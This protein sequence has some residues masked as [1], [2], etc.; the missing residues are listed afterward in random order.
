[1]EYRTRSRT[2]AGRGRHVGRIFEQNEPD[3]AFTSREVNVP[4]SPIKHRSSMFDVEKGRDVVPSQN[5]GHLRHDFSFG[6]IGSV[7]ANDSYG[8]WEHCFKEQAAGA[9]GGRL[10]AIPSNVLYPSAIARFPEF[11]HGLHNYRSYLSKVGYPSWAG[12]GWKFPKVSLQAGFSLPNFLLEL[13]ESVSLVHSWY[14]RKGLLKRYHAIRGANEGLKEQLKAAANERLAHVYG[15]ELFIADAIRLHHLMSTWKQRADKYLSNAGTV[16]RSYKVP[17]VSGW[18]GSMP[19]V[20]FPVF[21]VQESYLDYGWSVTAECHA[22]LYY[23]YNMPD[24][25]SFINRLAQ[26]SDSFG[27]RPDPG[28]VWDAIPLSFVVD[29][30][31]NVSEW[32]HENY[33]RDWTKIDVVLG[34]F[35]HSGKVTVGRQ[36]RWYRWSPYTGQGYCVHAPSTIASRSD[37]YYSRVSDSFPG[38]VG[39]TKLQFTEAA[40]KLGRIL[41]ATALTLQYVIPGGARPKVD[42]PPG[43][44][45]WRFNYRRMK[46]YVARARRYARLGY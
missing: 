33:G 38:F 15:T 20:D 27:I 44:E 3:G 26:M 37:S 2:I 13:R 32:L 4:A 24:L 23:S 6:G 18:Y 35:A 42:W 28:I 36:L 29:W 22:V 39:P 34:Q 10:M 30:F 40:W 1:M 46:R 12:Q 19:Q 11:V 45:A 21:E 31:I 7:I 17:L 25:R 41:N 9:F 5:C 16:Q 43:Y 8:N 14:S